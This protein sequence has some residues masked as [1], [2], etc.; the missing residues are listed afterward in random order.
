MGMTAVHESCDEGRLLIINEALG[1][2]VRLKLNLNL[3]S[4]T[5]YGTLGI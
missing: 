1:F 5:S 3:C 4:I 2:G